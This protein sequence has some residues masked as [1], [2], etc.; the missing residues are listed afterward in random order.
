MKLSLFLIPH[1]LRQFASVLCELWI[2]Q[3]AAAKSTTHTSMG[4]AARCPL[5]FQILML[6]SHIW[7]HESREYLFFHIPCGLA[8]ARKGFQLHIV[9]K[10]REEIFYEANSGIL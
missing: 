2:L 3:P 1:C 5:V 9:L 6:L 4:E 10:G 7:G 8:Q